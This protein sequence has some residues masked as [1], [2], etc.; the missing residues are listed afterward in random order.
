MSQGERAH[1][2]VETAVGTRITEAGGGEKEN[3]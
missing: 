3:T 2:V 1:R